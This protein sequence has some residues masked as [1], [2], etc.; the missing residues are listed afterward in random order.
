MAG[1][2]A[3]RIGIALG[4]RTVVAVVLGRKGAPVAWASGTFDDDGPGL[5]AELRRAFGEVK[6]ALEKKGGASTGGATASVAVLPPLADCR[7][8]PFPPL[9][10][11]EAEAVLTRDVARYFLGANRP[12]VV[13]VRPP[14]R[15]GGGGSA[16]RLGTP[17]GSGGTGERVEPP[18]PLLAAAVSTLLLE[19]IRG[20]LV[21]AGW[22]CGTLS[23]AQGAWLA[24]AAQGKAAP[25]QGLVAVVGGTAHVFRLGADLPEGIR[26]LPAEDLQGVANA[27]GH[28]GG[29]ALALGSG[30]EADRVQ[31]ALSR[32]GWSVFPDPEGWASAEEGAA[33]RA[34][35]G[36][37]EL[38]P[39]SLA[40]ARVRTSRRRALAMAGGAAALLLASALANLWGANRELGA[41]REQRAAI[42]SEVAPLL[43]AR[44][45]LAALRARV[46]A[47]EALE[48]S[49]PVWTRSL[50]E[51]SA[52]LPS[53]T[54]LTAFY[55]SGDTV[56][57]EAAGDRAGEAIQ[58]LRESG[59]FEDVRLQG[60]VERELDDGETVEERFRLRARLPAVG[61]E[62]ER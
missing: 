14:G 30:P 31:G 3:A 21:A 24:A 49:T 9:G 46:Q 56:E 10:R 40:E 26:Q 8:I 37:L 54:Y 22:R 62:G 41:L 20:A 55:A 52:L 18:P 29:R 2:G 38:V 28:G 7:L 57:I 53:D 27:L 12:R 16:L 48:E 45:S 47:L 17:A 33:A 42:R 15:A 13:A 25:L 44:D 59:L 5:E 35:A 4:S 23:A 60:L 58:I 51:L 61:G 11:R 50:V 19:R 43:E 6:A 39:P 1:R 32:D 36:G 34:G